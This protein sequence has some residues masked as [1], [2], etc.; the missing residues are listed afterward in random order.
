MLS[1]DV[2]F[3]ISVSFLFLLS[4]DS[5]WIVWA[6]VIFPLLRSSYF[7]LSCLEV[8]Y[9]DFF[10]LNWF[11]LQTLTCI[12]NLTKLK[13]NKYLYFIPDLHAIQQEAQQKVNS[14]TLSYCE[15]QGTE[16][17]QTKL[18]CIPILMGSNMCRLVEHSERLGLCHVLIPSSPILDINCTQ[19]SCSC[20]GSHNMVAVR[21]ILSELDSS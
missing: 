4:Q 17:H 16:S 21:Q 13:F 14:S 10:F 9:F 19:L 2:L 3:H 20:W 15:D 5:F 7:N 12:F 8:T 18:R 6:V 11:T 1:N